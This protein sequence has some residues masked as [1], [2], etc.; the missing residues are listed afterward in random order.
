MIA[1]AT[2]KKLY[3]EGVSFWPDQMRFQR[4]GC[5]EVTV[6]IGEG[7]MGEVYRAR[8]TKLNRD[9][10]LKVLPQ[11]SIDDPDRLPLGAVSSLPGCRL[12]TSLALA[13]QV[14]PEE[15]APVSWR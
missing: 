6:K 7:G 10:A 5:Y 9:V 12:T 11:A 14:E 2:P 1:S 8:D 15:T 3:P 4:I 13:Q